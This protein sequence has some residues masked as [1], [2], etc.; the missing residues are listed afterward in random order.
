MSYR[1]NKLFVAETRQY[2]KEE[3]FGILGHSGNKMVCHMCPSYLGGKCHHIQ[4]VEQEEN[5]DHPAVISFLASSN[6]S[7]VSSLA[8]SFTHF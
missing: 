8:F 4:L 1:H 6:V 3:Y 5:Q 7:G 2:G